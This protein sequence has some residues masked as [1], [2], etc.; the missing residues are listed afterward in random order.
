MRSRGELFLFFIQLIAVSNCQLRQDGKETQ[1][2]WENSVFI[3]VSIKLAL[4]Y[5]ESAGIINIGRHAWFYYRPH[6]QEFSLCFLIWGQGSSTWHNCISNFVWNLFETMKTFQVRRILN[7]ST[8]KVAR[9]NDLSVTWDCFCWTLK[10]SASILSHLLGGGRMS[11]TF[12]DKLPY[13]DQR[14]VLLPSK[15][16]CY[17][18]FIFALAAI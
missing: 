10:C 16:K 1:R 3:G 7:Y 13:S 11:F 2:S 6:M 17:L 9:R 5:W 14:G 18:L 8:G 4:F 15:W 12:M